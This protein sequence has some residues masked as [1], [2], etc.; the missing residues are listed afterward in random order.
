MKKLVADAG[1][2]DK[3]YVDSA[4]THGYHIGNPSDPRSRQAG[5]RRGYVFDHFARKLHPRDFNE[6]DYILA[7]DEDN[8]AEIQSVAPRSEHRAKAS[9]ILSHCADAEC[10]EVPDP[11]YG[12]PMGFEHVLDL[13]EHACADLLAKI[14]KEHGL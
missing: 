10:S 5:E 4:G 12:G 8:M 1:L 13:L 11:Y 2:Q 6:F 3:I 7:A 9:L 14:R